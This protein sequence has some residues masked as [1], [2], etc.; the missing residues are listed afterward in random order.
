MRGRLIWRN[1]R[2]RTHSGHPMRT[3][4]KNMSLLISVVANVG[5]IWVWGRGHRIWLV[6]WIE[7]R[8]RLRVPSW[9]II[10]VRWIASTRWKRIHRSITFVLWGS[11]RLTWGRVCHHPSFPPLSSCF[12]FS[13]KVRLGFLCLF[14]SC[15]HIIKCLTGTGQVYGLI[16]G[17]RLAHVN[18]ALYVFIFQ[19]FDKQPN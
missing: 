15:R 5:C 2:G 14:C 13:H 1:T 6:G 18:M 16:Y 8:W 3:P 11:C 12:D 7:Q 10:W 4:A 17:L 9:I 19:A